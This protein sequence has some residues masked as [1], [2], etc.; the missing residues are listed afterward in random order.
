M[1][2]L[3]G[4]VPA[5]LILLLSWAPAAGGVTAY[6]TW[7]TPTGYIKLDPGWTAGYMCDP[8]NR[9]C[10]DSNPWYTG[11]SPGSGFVDTRITP[12]G[13]VHANMQWP[14]IN[15]TGGRWGGGLDT[16]VQGGYASMV[17][18]LGNTSL[19]EL[20]GGDWIT[21]GHIRQLNDAEGCIEFFFK[22]NWNPA[23]DSGVHSLMHISDDG[24]TFM[25]A[26]SGSLWSIIR[27]ADNVYLGY[28]LAGQL[29]AGWN[30]IALAW[31]ATSVRTYVNGV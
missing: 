18:L 29:V 22:P 23:T 30:H 20:V 10:A 17:Y 5:G 15:A 26:A 19:G 12:G 7:N 31:D 21:R 27:S 3:S 16:S 9:V 6:A 11:P 4:V 1:N 28:P 2:R 24:W 13:T 25:R 8:A 14:S